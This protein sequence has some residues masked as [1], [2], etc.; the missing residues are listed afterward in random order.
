MRS[1]ALVF[2]VLIVA[3][4]A[5]EVTKLAS[6]SKLRKLSHKRAHVGELVLTTQYQEGPKKTDAEALPSDHLEIARLFTQRN[7]VALHAADRCGGNVI[8]IAAL[9]HSK[10]PHLV[11][12]LIKYYTVES[13]PKLGEIKTKLATGITSL[14]FGDLGHLSQCVYLKVAGEGEGIGAAA[15]RVDFPLLTGYP[16][17]TTSGLTEASA[18]EDQLKTILTPAGACWPFMIKLPPVS[19]WTLVCHS[20]ADSR[21]FLYDPESIKDHVQIV[22]A[23]DDLERFNAYFNPTN[24]DGWAL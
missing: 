16:A 14:T 3:A 5:I 13:D 1:F 10:L 18:Y 19:H 12:E 11:D 2:L 21:V 17:I 22:T 9:L 4:S 8:V 15:M 20:I 23:K 24:R 7:G 6:S